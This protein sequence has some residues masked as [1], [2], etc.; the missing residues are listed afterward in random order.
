MNTVQN[1]NISFASKFK[2]VNRG[3][4]ARNFEELARRY[5]RNVYLN[6]LEDHYDVKASV[7]PLSE[8]RPDGQFIFKISCLDES[9]KKNKVGK[10]LENI[11]GLREVFNESVVTDF[12]DAK[13]FIDSSFYT[14]LCSRRWIGDKFVEEKINATD[15][16][17]SFRKGILKA[18]KNRANNP[19]C[20]Q[21]QKARAGKVYDMIEDWTKHSKDE[22]Y[23]KN[24][25][26]LEKFY[27]DKGVCFDLKMNFLEP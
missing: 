1:Q 21:E 25:E 13:R 12:S 7:R 24:F 2:L 27:A 18:L 6:M 23:E 17:R 22:L 4:S 3:V 16:S 9:K 5:D 8:E 14:P 15:P 10:L 11:F 26:E 19:K 20:D